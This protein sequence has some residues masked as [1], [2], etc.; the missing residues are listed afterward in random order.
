MATMIRECLLALPKRRERD[1]L[2]FGDPSELSGE[3]IWRLA[4]YH[5]ILF[6]TH[7]G[8]VEVVPFNE[9]ISATP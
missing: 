2:S 3:P 4:H 9:M 5:C 6:K 1:H 8:L 7:P